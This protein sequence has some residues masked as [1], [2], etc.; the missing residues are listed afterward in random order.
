V[1][2]FCIADRLNSPSW[3]M[4]YSPKAC[5]VFFKA[6]GNSQPQIFRASSKYNTINDSI[7]E[8]TLHCNKCPM[9]SQFYKV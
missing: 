5:A 3:F 9:S 6:P 4:G 2:F 1:L 8:S 7:I